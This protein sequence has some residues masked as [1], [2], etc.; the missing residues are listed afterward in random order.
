TDSKVKKS[1]KK[2]F[3]RNTQACTGT[4]KPHKFISNQGRYNEHDRAHQVDEDK[5]NQIEKSPADNLEHADSDE[6][7]RD[8]LIEFISEVDLE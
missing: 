6:E 8:I 2:V 1:F 3:G 7:L 4:S 5:S